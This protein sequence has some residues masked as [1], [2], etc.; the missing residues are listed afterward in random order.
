M[1]GTKAHGS[2]IKPFT[3]YLNIYFYLL[4]TIIYSLST[5]RQDY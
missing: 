3:G 4:G 1:V 2:F 5:K